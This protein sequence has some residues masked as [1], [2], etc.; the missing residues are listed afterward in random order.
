MKYVRAIFAAL[1]TAWV[2]ANA[3]A[4][5]QDRYGAALPPGYLHTRGSQIVDQ[6]GRPVR[7]AAIGWSGGDNS[8]F[9]PEGLY[10]VNYRETIQAMRALGFNTIRLPYCDLWVGAKAGAMPRN[11][12]EYTSIDYRRNPDLKGL[13]ALEVLDRVIDAA[14][15]AGLKIIID[16][17]NNSCTAGQ[18]KNGLWYDDAV[19]AETFEA[20]WLFLARRYRGNDTIIGYDLN[21]EPLEAAGWGSGG[22]N[23]W[24]AQAQKLGRMIQAIDPGPLIIVEGPQTYNRRPN[25]PDPGPQGNL[26]GVR[27]LP[28]VLDVPNKLV[29]SVHE[30]PP[31]VFDAGF[32]R[33]PHSLVAQMNRIWGFVVKEGIAPVWVGEMGSS[34][35]T[36]TDR[37]WARTITAYLD[38]K[39]GELGGPTFSGD[40][41]GIGTGWWCWG[42]LDNWVPNGVLSNWNGTPRPDQYRIVQQLQMRTQRA[43][44]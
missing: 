30:Y 4:S 40:E 35:E 36:E 25:M 13:T 28:I 3:P 18:Q 15:D 26:Q 24:H 43:D 44:R 38:G 34:L 22:V 10:A 20:N 17:H 12:R 32:N 14:R 37:M 23:D 5:A 16:H 33:D 7:I 31:S 21:N 19:S 2:G 8:A 29:Y 39:L 9:V 1:I 41:Q 11:D 27:V 6:R 42:H